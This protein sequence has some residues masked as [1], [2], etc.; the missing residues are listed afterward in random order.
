MNMAKKIKKNIIENTTEVAGTYNAVAYL[1]LSV[2]KN[3]VPSDSIENQLCII[4]DFIDRQPDIELTNCYID[5]NASDGN[6]K[7]QGFQQMLQDIESKRIDC[8]IV[9]D[10]SR[11]SRNHLKM[12]FYLQ[13]HFPVSG[14]RFISVNAGWDSIDRITHK[15]GVKAVP[16]TNLI[17]EAFIIDIQKKKQFSIDLQIAQ[18][19]FAAPRA[20]YDYQKA[21]GDCHQ[22]EIDE[23]AA[24]FVCHIF[25]MA[26]QRMG[27]NEIVRHLNAEQIPNPAQYAITKGLTGNYEQGNGLWNTRSVKKILTRLLFRKNC[28]RMCR[29]YQTE[30]KPKAPHQNLR[31]KRMF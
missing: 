31:Q 2:V 13:K 18:G 11:F 20:P 12:G 7:R 15:D 23:T 1:R 22:L 30:R 9:K 8:V 3:H 4:K 29:P 16:L 5:T 19:G 27:L 24:E 10:L 6:F 21:S 25:D 17:N 26:S 14:V 28:L